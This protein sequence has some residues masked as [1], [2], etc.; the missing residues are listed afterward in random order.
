MNKRL[1]ICTM[2]L[3]CS[4]VELVKDVGQIPYTLSTQFDMEASLAC[5]KVDPQGSNKHVLREVSLLPVVCHGNKS[6]TGML[7]ILKYAKKF[8]WINFYHGGRTV[9][10]WA[11]LYHILNPK[12]K[13]YLKLDMDFRLCD[14]YD[15][16]KKE[17]KIFRKT[18][19]TVDL[20]SVESLVVKERIQKYTNKEISIISNGYQSSDY[21][22]DITRKRDNCFITVG[23]LGT[24]QKATD[25]L[26]EAFAVSASEH[27]W[28][29]KLI[30]SIEEDFKDYIKQY[31]ERYPNLRE[32]IFFSGEIKDRKQLYDEY[33]KAR[34]FVLPSRW[35]SFGIVGGGALSCGCRLILSDQIPP[36]KEFTNQN[37]FGS[38]V[39]VDDVEGLAKLMVEESH[40]QYEI[41]EI[42]RIRD[43]AEKNFS[44]NEICG[45]L[46]AQIVNCS[47]ESSH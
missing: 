30:G 41:S 33:C 31:F 27:D 17:R 32:R 37:E 2:Y 20:V 25:V 36:M 23:R 35:E 9:Y 42:L 24:R 28:K 5:C 14:K 15:S 39:K 46:H 34:V 21:I 16:S 8:D 3:P 12:G 7:F 6:I 1:K 38:I 18:T 45:R 43:Y 29:L 19:E 47:N 22:P 10:Y 40:R 13:I 4:N 11:K 44:W 26:L